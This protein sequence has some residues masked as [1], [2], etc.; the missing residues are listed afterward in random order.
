M[1]RKRTDR[2]QAKRSRHLSLIAEISSMS[3]VTALIVVVGVRFVEH[4]LHVSLSKFV[5]GGYP[6]LAIAIFL[7]SSLLYM[8]LFFLDSWR[9]FSALE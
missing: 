5:E 6:G 3:V 7:I 8:V 4:S 2:K 9:P 1:D